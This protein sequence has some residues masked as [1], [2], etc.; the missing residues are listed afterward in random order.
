MLEYEPFA[1][2]SGASYDSFTFQVRDDGGTAD[3]GTDTDPT[4]NTITFNI[5]SVEPPVI[6]NIGQDN[7]PPTYEEDGPPVFIYLGQNATVTDADSPN[8]D[9]GFLRLSISGF[10]LNGVDDFGIGAG[11]GITVTAQGVGGLVQFEGVTVGR[12]TVDQDGLFDRLASRDALPL[13]LMKNGGATE[14]PM[15]VLKPAW[16]CTGVRWTPPDA[17]L[18]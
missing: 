16:L 10:A 14:M 11:N 9:G 3:G 15:W 4:P 5:A 2:G 6:A 17:P 7:Q 13:E 1:E 12:I 8:F 18:R